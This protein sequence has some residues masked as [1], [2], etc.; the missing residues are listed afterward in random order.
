[1]VDPANYQGR[2]QAL[3][4]HTFLDSY[5]RDQLMK[6]GRY[7]SFTYVDLFAGPWQSQASDYSDTS[8][9]IAL[10]RMVEAKRALA[11]VGVDLQLSALRFARVDDGRMRT[12]AQRPNVVIL[13]RLKRNDFHLIHLCLL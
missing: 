13:E 4:K 8:F 7:G 11:K 10:H 9:G 12:R 5:M 2:E 6:V 1:M 3:V